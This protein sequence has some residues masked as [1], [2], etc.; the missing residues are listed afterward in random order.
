[1]G[2]NLTPYSIAIGWENRY[3]LT[4]FFRFINKENIDV[5][6]IDK[7]SDIDYDVM[8]SREKIEINKIHSNY[9]YDK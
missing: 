3:F 5:N 7:L 6:D 8:M 4:P 9:D 1:M 2:N